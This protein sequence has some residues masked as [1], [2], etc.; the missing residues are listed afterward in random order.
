M[1][2]PPLSLSTAHPL[3]P[4]APKRRRTLYLFEQ[5]LEDVDRY[6]SLLYLAAAKSGRKMT[7][8]KTN[9]LRDSFHAFC[10]THIRPQLAALQQQPSSLPDSAPVRSII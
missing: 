4:S 9:H 7:F 6:Y 3:P 8:S 10:N 2:A 5:D 1:N